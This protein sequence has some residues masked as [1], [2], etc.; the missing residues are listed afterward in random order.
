MSEATDLFELPDPAFWEALSRLF[1]PTSI[2]SFSIDPPNRGYL[3]IA[4]QE[5]ERELAAAAAKQEDGQHRFAYILAVSAAHR[6]FAALGATDQQREVFRHLYRALSGLERGSSEP[7]LEPIRVENRKIDP[8]AVWNAR[9]CLALA[10]ECRVQAREPLDRASAAVCA[11]FR[12]LGSKRRSSK[13]DH[14]RVQNWRKNLKRPPGPKGDHSLLFNAGLALMKRNNL[15]DAQWRAALL[16]GA[17]NFVQQAAAFQAQ[18]PDNDV[19][20]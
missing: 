19:W 1:D 4:L 8:T 18:A 2:Q 5:A 17:C 12:R 11:A 20:G 10:L 9:A 3:K 15:D 13:A 6:V 14:R 16:K 7:T